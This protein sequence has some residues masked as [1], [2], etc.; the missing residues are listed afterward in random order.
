MFSLVLFTD[1]IG[2]DYGALLYRLKPAPLKA[3]S[4]GKAGEGAEGSSE[5]PSAQVWQQQ[6]PLAWLFP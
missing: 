1:F 6:V 4:P 2:S 3:V 5:E